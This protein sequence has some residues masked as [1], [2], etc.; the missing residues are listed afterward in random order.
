[1]SPL[2]WCQRDDLWVVLIALLLEDGF[3]AIGRVGDRGEDGHAPGFADVPHILGCH[4]HGTLQALHL[5]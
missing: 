1:M 5:V 2:P 4:N 3:A